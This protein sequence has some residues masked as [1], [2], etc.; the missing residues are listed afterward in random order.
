MSKFIILMKKEIKDILTLQTIIPIILMFLLFN[1]IG[2]FMENMIS[3]VTSTDGEVSAKN[4]VAV[5]DLDTTDG[6]NS[7]VNAINMSGYNI[8]TPS[9]TDPKAAYDTHKDEFDVLIVIPKG[10]GETFTGTSGI[11]ADIAVYSNIESFSLMTMISGSTISAIIDSVNQSLSDALLNANLNSEAPD[12]EFI[13]NPIKTTEYSRV[14]GNIEQIPPSAVSSLVSS[15]TMF[16]PIIIFVIVVFSSQTLAGS[17]TGEKF[18]KTLETLLTTPVRRTYILFAKMLS[19]SLI[20][21]AYAVTFMLSYDNL[22]STM[23]GGIGNAADVDFTSIL[24][25]LGISFN[26][27]TYAILGIS[28]F[29]SIIIGLCIAMVIGVLAEDMKK[30]QSLLMPLIMMLMIPYMVSMFA[31]INTLPMV[32]RV[33]LY[34]IPFTHTFTAIGNVFTSNFLLLGVGLAYQLIFLLIALAITR[35]IF[36]TDKLFTLK[37][38][39]S[40]KKKTPEN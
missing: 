28:T 15:Q 23:T 12:L 31:D 29:L 16:V 6:S 20:S 40:K 8:V 38:D 27:G 39:F 18:D 5:I 19:A 24:A 11:S 35:N 14:N 33:L 30:L 25:N 22:I 34:I 17:M 4:T 1:G 21:L 9:V 13:K 36:A 37:I 26:V 7:L 32:A 2:M 3:S 10:F